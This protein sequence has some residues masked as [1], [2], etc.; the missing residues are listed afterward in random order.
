MIEMG[1]HAGADGGNIIAQGSLD[2]IEKNSNSQIAPFLTNSEKIIIRDK[3]GETFENG[4]IS[5][6]TSEIHNVKPLDIEIPKG[7][8]TAVTGVSGS[9]KTTLL[10]EALYPAVK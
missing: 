6:K 8:L 10:L 2:E 1:P 7:K 5:I 3:S 9:G 4:S